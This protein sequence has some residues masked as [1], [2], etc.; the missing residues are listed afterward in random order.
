VD[1]AQVARV[2]H[3]FSE[4]NIMVH[5]YLMYGFPKHKTEQETID[6]LLEATI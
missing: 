5:A 2:T 6:S 3:H 4:N 1:I